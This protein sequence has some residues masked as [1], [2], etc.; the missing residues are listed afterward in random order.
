MCHLYQMYCQQAMET[1]IDNLTSANVQAL[2]CSHQVRVDALCSDVVSML[3]LLL[4]TISLKVH[5]AINAP[6]QPLPI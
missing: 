1:D 5:T 4:G 3:C 6:L 2:V